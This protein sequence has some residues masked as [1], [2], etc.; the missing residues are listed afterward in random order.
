MHPNSTH[1]EEPSEYTDLPTG[2]RESSEWQATRELDVRAQD[3]QGR[4]ALGCCLF[5][6]N[7]G[8]YLL[9]ALPPMGDVRGNASEMTIYTAEHLITIEGKNLHLLVWEMKQQRLDNLAVTP[10]AAKT[11][12][13]D[14][15]SISSITASLRED[16]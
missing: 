15:W 11:G 10:E 13:T 16:D 4:L 8:G 3:A 1:P 2:E 6:L 5:W 7:R 9:T 12:D 14:R